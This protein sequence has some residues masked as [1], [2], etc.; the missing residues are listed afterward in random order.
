M[1]L[2][3]FRHAEKASPFLPDPVLSENGMQQ[4]IALLEKVQNQELPKPTQLWV[5]PRV[6]AR[7][8]FQR[9]SESIQIPLQIHAELDEKMSGENHHEFRDRVDRFLTKAGNQVG[10]LFI[11][12]HYDWLEESLQL[13]PCD[14]DLMHEIHSHWGSLQYM[15][16]DKKENIYEFIES[17]RISR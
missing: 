10:V 15:A 14:T 6:R 16:F 12:S 4:A 11:C 1:K 7:Q 2:Y 8:S 17:K 3:L 5:S 9:I 13:I